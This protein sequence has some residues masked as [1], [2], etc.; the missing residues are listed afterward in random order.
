M[1][2]V[3]ADM[4]A[5]A[6]YQQRIVQTLS[7]LEDQICCKDDLIERTKVNIRTAIDRAEDAERATYTSL[8]DA[9]DMLCEAEQR[10]R[11]YN[12][13]L[14]E[15]QEPTTTPDFYY[16]NVAE[17]ER[18]YSYARANRENAE[19]TLA[20]FEVYVRNYEQQQADGIEHFKK[21]LEMSGKF[22]ENYI[23]KLNEVK[24]CTT[25][26]GDYSRATSR[27]EIGTSPTD[28]P[29][30]TRT[31]DMVLT[32]KSVGADGEFHDYRT[33]IYFSDKP[34]NIIA[35]HS[36]G[37]DAAQIQSW[38]N[39]HYSEWVSSLSSQERSAISCY[40]SEGDESYR[41]INTNLRAG[42]P[43]SSRDE[44]LVNCIHSALSRASLPCDVQVYRALDDNGI[45]ELALY[46]NQGKLESGAS[47][48]DSAFMSCSLLANNS[49]NSAR[50]NKYILRL[51]AP[52]GLH[53]G[54]VR[55]ISTFASEQELLIDKDHSI[56]ITGIS[57]CQRKEITK[58]TWDND[59][60][61]IVDGVLS[62]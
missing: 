27:V 8:R 42:I 40:T 15:D 36:F 38:G 61:V 9:E 7:I 21:L 43:L 48:Q 3:Y 46:C 54:Y 23:K 60:I 35:P 50:S 25:S 5:L 56:Y 18:E 51:S 20:S 49:F 22:F 47:L 12:A 14:A 53:A 37:Y 26:S 45:R 19:N 10:T 55:R 39:Q 31:A 17:H 52:Q 4:G 33:E 59:T 58:N 41:K 34:N 13:N 30:F 11:N 24:K 1:A 62:F 44:N 28:E 32:G 29:Q 57:Q 6:E 2:Y 16:E